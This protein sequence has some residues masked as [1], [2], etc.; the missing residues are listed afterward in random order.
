LS[1]AD[2][3]SRGTGNGKFKRRDLG[4]DITQKKD[5]GFFREQNNA[6]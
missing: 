2:G 3:R 6:G 1:K 5:A 4:S